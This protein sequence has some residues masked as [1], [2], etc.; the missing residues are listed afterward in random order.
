MVDAKYIKEIAKPILGRSAKE[1]KQKEDEKAKK[2]QEAITAMWGSLWA[3]DGYTALE[4]ATNSWTRWPYPYPMPPGVA[5]Q[6][7]ASW[8]GKGPEEWQPYV[9]AGRNPPYAIY[10]R[11][12]TQ[13]Q[14]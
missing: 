5:A 7:M 1:K 11:P 10:G 6:M 14:F 8:K 4:I 9:L 12:K 2:K 3:N 13:V